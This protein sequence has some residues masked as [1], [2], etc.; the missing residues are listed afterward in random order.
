MHLVLAQKE[1]NWIVN[2]IN[3]DGEHNNSQVSVY[4]TVLPTGSVE[5]IMNTN[6]I[7]KKAILQP[8]GKRLSIKKEKGKY[9]IPVP[10]VAIH[11]IV[12]L[13]F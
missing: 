13:S 2:I 11:S 10:P 7:I 8:E 3:I 5:L 4:D 12:E 9:I 6:R 1:D